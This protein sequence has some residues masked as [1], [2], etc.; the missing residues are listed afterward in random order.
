MEYES[1]M[2]TSKPILLPIIKNRPD[3]DYTLQEL[4]GNNWG[5]EMCAEAFAVADLLG[6]KVELSEG[7]I[8]EENE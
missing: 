7:V 2:D 4:L 5:L 1:I 3:P 6:I 8:G